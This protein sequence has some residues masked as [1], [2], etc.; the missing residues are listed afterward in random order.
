MSCVDRTT[1][2]TQDLR[3]FQL[4]LIFAAIHTTS[5]TATSI[6]YTLAVTPDYIA[7]LREEIRQV[8]ADNDDQF[9]T[10]ALQKM[11]KLDSYMKE[12]IRV[13]NSNIST[14]HLLPHPRHSFT[15][16]SCR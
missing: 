5:T 13:H 14:Y 3:R 15:P 12:C 2:L 9:T 10:R 1:L 4:G 7:P 11:E 8:M 16:L 6:L